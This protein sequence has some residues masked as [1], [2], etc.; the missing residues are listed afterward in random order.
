[1]YNVI[2][3]VSFESFFPS[4]FTCLS[5]SWI[6]LF[7]KQHRVD[8]TILTVLKI[9]WKYFRMIFSPKLRILQTLFLQK[10]AFLICCYFWVI[11]IK[12]EELFLF[13][14]GYLSQGVYKLLLYLR[15]LFINYHSFWNKQDSSWE[16]TFYKAIS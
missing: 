4:K 1:M 15:F 12:W 7:K 11:W 6:K 14:I 3:Q 10:K 16:T 13:E 2:S 9:Y 8:F 5:F